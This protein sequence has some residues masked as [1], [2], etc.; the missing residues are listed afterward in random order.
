M[1]GC[2]SEWRALAAGHALPKVSLT[3]FETFADARRYV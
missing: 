1:M 2:L 3:A